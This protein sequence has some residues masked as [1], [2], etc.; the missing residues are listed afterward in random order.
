MQTNY[1][2]RSNPSSM[3]ASQIEMFDGN[4]YIDATKKVEITSLLQ[5][6]GDIIA[7]FGTSNQ[8]SLQGLKNLVNQHLVSIYVPDI[9]DSAYK[10]SQ[11]VYLRIGNFICLYAYVYSN[12]QTDEWH[13]VAGVPAPKN[14]AFTFNSTNLNA[15][16]QINHQGVF[17]NVETRGPKQVQTYCVCYYAK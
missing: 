3:C 13:A 15:P 16:M 5:V 10:G 17:Q 2:D 1:M 6:T 14:G 11:V 7:G 8:V 4:V 9:A 12:V